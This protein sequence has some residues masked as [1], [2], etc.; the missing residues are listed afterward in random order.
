[1]VT[2]Y[3]IL[4]DPSWHIGDLRSR[5]PPCTMMEGT[6][7]IP[8]FISL[9]PAVSLYYQVMMTA[10]PE[11]NLYCSTLL[12]C[13]GWKWTITT[14]R[15]AIKCYDAFLVSSLRHC[16]SRSYYLGNRRSRHLSEEH[17]ETGLNDTTLRNSYNGDHPSILPPPNTIEP[18]C[19]NSHNWKTSIHGPKW[20][21]SSS[22]FVYI[23]SFSISWYK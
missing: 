17:Y 5:N 10:I 9:G 15:T 8:V 22:F 12:I 18:F 2:L 19:I 1:M 14:A 3:R 16:F 13:P 21:P 7:L 20:S 4:T 11:Q 6:I 23:I